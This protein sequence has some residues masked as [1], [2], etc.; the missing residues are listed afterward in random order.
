MIN[1]SRFNI[2]FDKILQI[3]CKEIYDSPLSMLRENVQNAY[4][5]ILIRKKYDPKMDKGVITISIDGK[6]IV[7][8]DNGVGMS[9]ENLNKNFWTAG[10]SGKNNEYAKAAGVVG[11]FGI[12]AMA[13]FGVCDDMKVVTRYYEDTATITSWVNKEDLANQEECIQTTMEGDTLDAPG[14]K[15]IVTLDNEHNISANEAEMYLKPFVQYLT[16]PVLI[17]GKCISCDS[18]YLPNK[19]ENE[20]SVESDYQTSNGVSFH[21]RILLNKNNS[22]INPR[23]E[24]RNIC[25][26]YYS[27]TL[28]DIILNSTAHSLFGLRNGFGLSQI[29]ISSAFGL[30]GVANLLNLTPTAGRDAISRMSIDFVYQLVTCADNLVAETIAKTEMADNCRE[31]LQYIKSFG[32]YDLADNVQ[33]SIANSEDRIPLSSIQQE[34]DGK[35]VMYYRGADKSIINSFDDRDNIV[36][37][38]S[39]DRVRNHIQVHVLKAKKINEISDSPQIISILTS[40]I[41]ASEELSI[42]FKIKSIVEDD[43]LVQECKVDYAEISHGLSILA[44]MESST[45]H[46]Y[47]KRDAPDLNTLK[48]I[49]KE[50]YG[51]FEPFVKDFVRTRLYVKISAYIPSSQKE[52]ADAL[53]EMLQRKKELYT[54]ETSDYG[55]MDYLMNEYLQGRVNIEDVFRAVNRQKKS[56]TQTLDSG[57]VGN[58]QDVLGTPQL[59]QGLNPAPIEQDEYDAF[60]PIMRL[61]SKSKYKILTTSEEL[62]IEGYT[63]FLALSDK[64][65]HDFRD[66]FF[67]PHTTRVIWS[68]HKIIYVFTHA[69]GNLTLYYE[70]EL[71]KRLS[72]YATGGK[73]IKS[74]TIITADK[75]YVPINKE[76]V[77]YFD[78]S[79]GKLTFMVRYDSVKN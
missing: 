74:A 58:V 23:I 21:Y 4:D 73:A 42:L 47:M 38:P 30:G 34:I 37:I 1:R 75:V 63:S 62:N 10:A 57:H 5:A 14:T 12:G 55:N 27:M 56:Q 44:Q 9:M 61:E 50:D 78:V 16:V 19:G 52:G 59:K 76:L 36:L 15:I 18:F 22:F 11:T 60:P 53:Y 66:F 24:L 51:L 29:P 35:K 41:L 8:S 45:L 26:K 39:N 46:I 69:S 28:G 33:I 70:M 32:H 68:M 13:N 77:N 3:L 71:K 65:N 25:S 54:I 64:M 48:K 79:S 2:K 67:Q 31:L 40:E 72:D 6:T 49:Y 7:V 20:L 43:Y 17:N